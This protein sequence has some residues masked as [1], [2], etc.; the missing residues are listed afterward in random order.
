MQFILFKSQPSTCS[1]LGM[2]DP[3]LTH[4]K[5]RNDFIAK[6]WTTGVHFSAGPMI[7][8]FP[9]PPRPDRFWGPPSLLFNGHWGALPCVYFGRDLKLTIHLHLVPRLR[10]SGA[11]PSLPQKFSWRRA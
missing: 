7:G 9:S 11:I 5:I 6:G 4:I 8:F 2:S 1:S 10:I 3:S